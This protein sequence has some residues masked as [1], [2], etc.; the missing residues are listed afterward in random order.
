MLKFG[1]HNM[2]CREDD[3]NLCELKLARAHKLIGGLGGEKARWGQNVEMLSTAL[4]L[5]PGDCIVAAG[6]LVS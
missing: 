6:F 2:H 5:L 3:M 1:W 4:T